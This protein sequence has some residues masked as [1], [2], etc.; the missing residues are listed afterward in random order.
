MGLIHKNNVKDYWSTEDI[1]STSFFPK[2]MLRDEYH[3]TLT[4]FHLSDNKIYHQK[5]SPDYDPR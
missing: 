2:I 5:G 3:N 4:F 1:I